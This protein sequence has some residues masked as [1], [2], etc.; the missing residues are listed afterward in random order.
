MS[1]RPFLLWPVLVVLA[2]GFLPWFIKAETAQ[3]KEARLN[4]QLK[5]VERELASQKNLLQSKQKETASIQR[6]VDILTY[7][8]NTAQLNIR[9]KQ[10]EIARL[11]GDIT[12]KQKTINVL[13]EQLDEERRSLSELLRQTRNLDDR[14]LIEIILSAGALSDLFADTQRFHSLEKKIQFS[15]EAARE[16]RGDTENQKTALEIRR[17]AETNAQK[18]IEAEKLKIEQ[19]NKE[20]TVLLNASKA[21]EDSYKTIIAQK[22]RERSAILNALYTLRGAQN[23]T[24]GQALEHAN[25]VSSKTGVRPAFLLAIITQESNLGEN[26]GTCNRPGDPPAKSYKSVMKPDRDVVPFEQICRE[27]GLD[28]STQPVSCPFGGGYGGAMG[29]AQFIPSTWMSVRNAV[30]AITGNRPANPW[31]PRD[32]FVASGLYLRDL[33]AAR[34]TYTAEIQAALKYYAG[35]NWSNPKNAFYGNQVMAIATRYQQQID[36]LQGN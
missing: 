1:S 19:L 29:P 17:Q 24:F 35:S 22:E 10:I 6:D 14:S 7:R 36:I 4:A 23:I 26:I 18:V 20:K 28:P 15:L 5:E 11:G 30:S 25:F 21:T 13:D 12:Q 8:I 3:E 33:G 2:L 9:A 16:M 27:L 34:G 32:A 31:D